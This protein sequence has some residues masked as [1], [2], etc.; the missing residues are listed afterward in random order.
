LRGI[1]GMASALALM[2]AISVGMNTTA[3]AAIITSQ[4]GTPAAEGSTDLGLT[5]TGGFMKGDLSWSHTGYGPI[6]DTIISAT[7]EIDLI[8]AEEPDAR[9][10][11]HAGFGG[12]LFGSAYGSNDGAPGPW[13]GLPPG[14]TSSDNLIN[15]SSDFFAD[16]ADGTFDIFGNNQNMIIWGSNRALLTIVT[17]EAGP[18][19]NSTSVPEPA[20][21]ALF[22]LGLAGLGAVRRKR[23]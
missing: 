12:D 5:L 20:G 22:G 7:L 6:T 1:A 8:D 14:G 15:I 10:D 17:E 2:G 4:V 9:L 11:L 3:D 23:S 19:I 21:L 13:R 18:I 16:I